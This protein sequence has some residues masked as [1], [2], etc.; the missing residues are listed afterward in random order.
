[1]NRFISGFALVGLFGC[2]FLSCEDVIVKDISHEV[3]ALIAPPENID[4]T[5]QSFTFWWNEVQ[6][7]TNYQLLI[8]SPNM[9]KPI[10]IGLDTLITKEKFQFTLAKGDYEWCV[11]ATNNGYKTSY[12]CR[13]ISIH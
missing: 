4:T 8:V 11:R 1:M 7:A 5:S 12:S 9:Q 2:A 3:V 6:G 10:T 13:K